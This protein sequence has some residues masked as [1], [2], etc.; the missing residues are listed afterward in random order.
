MYLIL[1][2]LSILRAL[3]EYSWF[4][5]SAGR[6]LPP[7]FLNIYHAA[8]II[9]VACHIWW[10]FP[11]LIRTAEEDLVVPLAGN[12]IGKKALGRSKPHTNAGRAPFPLSSRGRGPQESSTSATVSERKRVPPKGLAAIYTAAY[13]PKLNPEGATS[14]GLRPGAGKPSTK[15]SIST[16]PS[17]S[18]H[19]STFTQ[20]RSHPPSHSIN[21]CL[22]IPSCPEAPLLLLLLPLPHHLRQS[23]P[24]KPPPRTASHPAAGIT[25]SIE[26]SP[27]LPTTP[28]MRAPVAHKRQ[29]STIKAGYMGHS[30]S[31]AP[32]NAEDSMSVHVN[33][34]AGAATTGNST[35]AK[36]NSS[37][38]EKYGE[39]KVH[40]VEL[41]TKVKA[42]TLKIRRSVS[43]TS[44]EGS[45]VH[46]SSPTR[47]ALVRGSSWKAAAKA[48]KRGLNHRKTG[49]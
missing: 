14:E 40:L 41:T 7:H 49:E 8:Y 48:V 34:S 9:C 30:K 43:P 45:A 28:R 37:M 4:W 44:I 2:Y 32:A 46:G 35:L 36:Q 42:K 38:K 15:P 12:D 16:L 25:A 1:P 17:S 24:P 47:A 21:G 27:S 13:T 29:A 20:P 23:P 10:R 3:L 18:N 11:E 26:T 19:P 39:M 33:V 5:D 31:R 22:P 6:K